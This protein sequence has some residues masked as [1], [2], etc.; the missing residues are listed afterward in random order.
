MPERWRFEMKVPPSDCSK[1]S[2]AGNGRKGLSKQDY[3]MALTNTAVFGDVNAVP[4]DA[5]PRRGCQ[6]MVDPLGPT[7]GPDVRGLCPI[8]AA[9]G[10]RQTAGRARRRHQRQGRAQAGRRFRTFGSG[11][12]EAARRNAGCRIPGEIRREGDH[13][14][15]S[16]CVLKARRY[17]YD[18]RT[19]FRRVF[20]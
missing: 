18:P 12:S 4:P 14:S 6:G 13:A 2:V 9:A 20:R 16:P 17:E 11:H 10:C 19:P 15:K 5:G 7:P 3:T 8:I 1:C